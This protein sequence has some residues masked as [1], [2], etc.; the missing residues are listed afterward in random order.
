MQT[1]I[2]LD[3]VPLGI[4]VFNKSNQ[5]ISI[6][7][8]GR[9]YFDKTSN[10]LLEVIID[11]VTK[12]LNINTSVEKIIKYSNSNNYFVWRVKTELLLLDYSSPQVLVMIEDETVNSKLEQTILK[13]EKL[14]VVGQ[15]AIGSLVEIRNPLTS[16][17]GFCQLIEQSEIHR[18]YVEIISKE[19]EQ[20]QHIIDDCH[21]IANTAQSNNLEVIYKKFLTG[22]HNQIDC[23]KLIMVRDAFDNLVI[24]AAE[25]SVNI[26]VNNLINLLNSCVEENVY[27]IISSESAEESSFLNLNIRVHSNFNKDLNRPGQIE[28]N[29][30]CLQCKNNQ[31]KFEVVDNNTLAVNLQLPI[32]IPQYPN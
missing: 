22:I 32:I 14:A 17:R 13:A 18:E 25:E 29:I 23:Y 27:I 9:L 6:N 3:K 30:K 20:I 1:S 16:A 26:L 4:I 24:N 21:L 10:F 5:I 28:N 12:T 11:L 2:I 8:S 15:L 19:L 7:R 31:M